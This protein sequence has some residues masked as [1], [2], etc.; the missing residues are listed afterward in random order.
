MEELKKKKKKSSQIRAPWRH[1]HTSGLDMRER[2]QTPNLTGGTLLTCYEIAEISQAPF[3]LLV[4]LS[5]F[6]SVVST[7]L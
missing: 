7:F 2:L 4:E 1:M 5:A 6:C 3:F